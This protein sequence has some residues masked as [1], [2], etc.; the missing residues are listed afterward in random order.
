MGLPGPRPERAPQALVLGT[1]LRGELPVPVSLGTCKAAS[2]PWAPRA[3]LPGAGTPSAGRA[4]ASRGACEASREVFRDRRWRDAEGLG[5]R[6]RAQ[7]GSQGP[8]LGLDL[9]LP[10][11]ALG[12]L[13]LRQALPEGDLGATA[14]QAVQVGPGLLGDLPVVGACKA[15]EAVVGA[16]LALAPL[17]PCPG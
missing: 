17:R 13:R 7:Q 16:G 10:V 14:V 5:G 3:P 11:Q 8:G 2:R 15:Q 9:L 6:G 4:G 1:S 12:V